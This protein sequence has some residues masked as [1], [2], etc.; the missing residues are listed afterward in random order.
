MRSVMSAAVVHILHQ[1]FALCQHTNLLGVP[2]DWPKGH[3]W[4]ELHEADQATCADCRAAKR[5]R[6]R[7]LMLGSPKR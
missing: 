3:K 1:G 6:D 5:V 7:P 2:R 4:V